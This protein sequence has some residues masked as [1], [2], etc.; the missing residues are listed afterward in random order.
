MDSKSIEASSD[1]S[2]DD[3]TRNPSSVVPSKSSTTIHP[4]TL[5]EILVDTSDNP[6]RLIDHHMNPKFARKTPRLGTLPPEAISKKFHLNVLMGEICL[7][8]FQHLQQQQHANQNAFMVLSSDRFIDPVPTGVFA[9]PYDS[10]NNNH[11]P[12]YSSGSFDPSYPLLP[13]VAQPSSPPPTDNRIGGSMIE[14]G[15]TVSSDPDLGSWSLRPPVPLSDTDTEW[16]SLPTATTSHPEYES[17]SESKLEPTRDD[18]SHAMNRT[19]TDASSQSMPSSA[20]S[21]SGTIAVVDHPEELTMPRP[22]PVKIPLSATIIDE[23]PTPP[24]PA[25][26]RARAADGMKL[27]QLAFQVEQ[28]KSHLLTILPSTIR[29]ESVR[30]SSNDS[31]LPSAS[32]LNSVSVPSSGSVP[33]SLVQVVPDRTWSKFD[34]IKHVQWD[35]VPFSDPVWICTNQVSF[36][37]EIADTPPSAILRRLDEIMGNDHRRLEQFRIAMKLNSD[38]AKSLTD[39]LR[40]RHRKR[41]Q[42]FLDALSKDP[43]LQDLYHPIVMDW[44]VTHRLRWVSPRRDHHHPIPH[45][46]N[47]K[48]SLPTTTEKVRR[49]QPPSPSKSDGIVNPTPIAPSSASLSTPTPTSAPATAS[50]SASAPTVAS[51]PPVTLAVPVPAPVSIPTASAASAASVSSSDAALSPTRSSV[52]VSV[53]NNGSCLEPPPSTVTT[54]PRTTI[55][56]TS[57][58]FPLPTM[59][60]TTSATVA[61]APISILPPPESVSRSESASRPDDTVSVGDHSK[62]MECQTIESSDVRSVDPNRASFTARSSMPTP[63]PK[64]IDVETTR[65]FTV[66]PDQLDIQFPTEIVPTPPSL[67]PQPQPQPSLYVPMLLHHWNSH[68]PIVPMLTG[69]QSHSLPAISLSSMEHSINGIVS[70]QTRSSLRPSL[71]RPSQSRSNHRRSTRRRRSSRPSNSSPLPS[72]SQTKRPSRP[73]RSPTNSSGTTGCPAELTATSESHPLSSASSSSISMATT[74]ATSTIDIGSTSAIVRRTSAPPIHMTTLTDL[75]MYQ[76]FLPSSG[77]LPPLIV[78]FLHEYWSRLSTN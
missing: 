59:M 19:E 43:E 65:E 70:N 18:P 5:N 9:D 42:I 69:T 13:V 21:S 25:R 30:K 12:H 77:S 45:V 52:S 68:P 32:E 56:G 33:S 63:S 78:S 40:R 76:A 62:P 47:P 55:T 8:A 36:Q 22:S 6:T 20:L 10:M 14:P 75:D 53:S 50:A 16:N 39:D 60:L 72:S 2:S 67:A 64:L 74:V 29:T 15:M 46:D 41:C 17:K 58:T 37:L 38:Q 31:R 73:R 48:S 3:E 51:S 54:D 34:R 61:T 57:T 71:M 7:S 35:A 27:K 23:S 49:P 24:P 11:V 26:R 28:L 4:P 1:E 66:R 44:A